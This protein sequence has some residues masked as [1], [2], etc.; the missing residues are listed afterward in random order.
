MTKAM[1]GMT[2]AVKKK[3]VD[4]PNDPDLDSFKL[5]RFTTIDPKTST[6]RGDNGFYTKTS[7]SPQLAVWEYNYKW[8]AT[9]RSVDASE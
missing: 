3:W 9:L 1:I 6:K 8:L 7:Q 5:K 2:N 4:I